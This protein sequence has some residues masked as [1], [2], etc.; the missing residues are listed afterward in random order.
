MRISACFLSLL[1]GWYVCLSLGAEAFSFSLTNPEQTGVAVVLGSSYDPD[2]TFG[3]AQ[4]N[5]MA[6]YDYEQIMPHRAPEPL[7][8]KLE[9]SLGV[10]DS[11]RA[12]VLASANFFAF[13][14]LRKLETKV[15]RPYVEAGAGLAYGD[16]QVDGQGLRFNFNPQAGIGAEWLS[17]AGRRWYSAVRAYHLSNSGLHR[18]NRGIN[19]VTWMLG[20]SFR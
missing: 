2:P 20:F 14:Y 15:F 10:A 13:Y 4:V 6:L 16:F 3:F 7:R 19:A 8:F 12:R 18:D 17:A 11:S 1:A 5:L 9:G